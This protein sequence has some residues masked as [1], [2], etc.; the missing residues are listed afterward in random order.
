MNTE[1]TPTPQ[2]PSRQQIGLREERGTCPV[3]HSAAF[4]TTVYVRDE[5]V[6]GRTLSGFLTKWMCSRA[7]G[8]APSC[9]WERV[10]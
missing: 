8:N 2:S 6:S 4:S 5:E 7:E 10:L 3:C 9:Y 1:P